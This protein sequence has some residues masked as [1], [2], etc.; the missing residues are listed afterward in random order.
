MLGYTSWHQLIVYSCISCLLSVVLFMI[1]L[2]SFICSLS[3]CD[4]CFHCLYARAPSPLPHTLIG[5]LL[6]TLVLHIQNGRFV[7]IVQVLD[8]T[9]HVVRSW[10]LSLPD[11]SI[12]IPLAFLYSCDY[13]LILVYQIQSLFQFFIY[14]ISCVDTY[15]WYYNDRWWKYT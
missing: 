9:I 14:M 13:F 6:M 10:S 1:I 2:L 4:I 15:M 8:E 11:S 5:S 12:L 3:C 7:S